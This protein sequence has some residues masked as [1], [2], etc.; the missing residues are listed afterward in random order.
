[1]CP[2]CGYGIKAHYDKIAKRK[3]QQ[4]IYEAR[5]DNVKEPEKPKDDIYG[6]IICGVAAIFFLFM[7]VELPGLGLVGFVILLIMFIIFYN[8][9]VHAMQKYKDDCELYRTD[10]KAYQRKEVQKED[11]RKAMEASKPKCPQCNSTNIEKIS[12]VDRAISIQIVGLAS[13]KIGKQYKCK[14]CKFI[15]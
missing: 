14:N 7:T 3:Q 6:M 13:N 2:E 1:M 10:K 12:T 9:H 11:F 4:K 8:Q 15:W 5:I